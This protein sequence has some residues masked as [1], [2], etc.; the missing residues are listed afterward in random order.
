MH[1]LNLKKLSFFF[2][3]AKSETKTENPSVTWFD[4]DPLN[5]KSK[6][7]KKLLCIIALQL[8]IS[9]F[10]WSKDFNEMCLKPK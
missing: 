8:V 4:M 10:V 7:Q 5:N 3:S 9:L 1:V 2:K 6:C